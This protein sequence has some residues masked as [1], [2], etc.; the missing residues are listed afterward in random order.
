MADGCFRNADALVDHADVH[1]ARILAHHH[2][3]RG[4]FGRIVDGVL[5]QVLHRGDDRVLVAFDPHVGVVASR[6]QP[7]LRAA[8]RQHQVDMT[9]VGLHAIRIDRGAGHGQCGQPFRLKAMPGILHLL[10]VDEFLHQFGQS[11]GFLAY[12]TGEIPHRVRIVGRVG[13]GLGQQRDRARRRFQLMRHIRH[14]LAAHLLEMPAFAHIRDEQ[15]EQAIAYAAHPHAQ[16]SFARGRGLAGPHSP[17]RR[18][19]FKI[20]SRASHLKLAFTAHPVMLHLGEHVEH[21]VV[22]DMTGRHAAVLFDVV[23]RI[24]DGTVAVRQRHGLGQRAHER[25]FDAPL[26]LAGAEQ[27][28]AAYGLPAAVMFFD[29]DALA[30]FLACPIRGEGD[31]RHRR[32][33]QEN[34]PPLHSL[35]VAFS[36]IGV[37]PKDIFALPQ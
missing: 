34:L 23:T 12:T 32:D 5:H 22:A 29:G 2:T 21:I 27:R 17:A 4:V 8:V 6:F 33:H 30:A 25:L 7:Q 1:V 35:L 16:I 26:R 18:F 11:R 36:T 28:F 13:N 19:T 15:R 3:N 37:C 24:P 10:Q 31:C 14:E 9:P 20:G